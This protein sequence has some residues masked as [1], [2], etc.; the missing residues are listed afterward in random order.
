ML[1]VSYN[2]LIEWQQMKSCLANSLLSRLSL[3]HAAKMSILIL[4]QNQ[5][6]TAHIDFSTKYMD[7]DK[8]DPILAQP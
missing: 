1:L 8:P 4:W 5:L 3:P 7:L 6:S 2:K